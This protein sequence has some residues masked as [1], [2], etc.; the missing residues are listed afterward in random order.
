MVQINTSISRRYDKNRIRLCSTN[1]ASEFSWFNREYDTSDRV[2]ITANF[3]KAS[4]EFR[5]NQDERSEY[6]FTC[7]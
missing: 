1:V 5:V 4:A 7:C 3:N 6:N 2:Q